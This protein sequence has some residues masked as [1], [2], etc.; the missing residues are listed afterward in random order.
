MSTAKVSE[1]PWLNPQEIFLTD[2][3][4]DEETT[5]AVEAVNAVRAAESESKDEACNESDVDQVELF[6]GNLRKDVEQ[7]L[8]ISKLQ[9][10]FSTIS[11]ELSIEKFRPLQRGSNKAKH[12]FVKMENM[13]D[14]EKIVDNFDGYSDSE[15]VFA[16]RT[17]K[18]CPKHYKPSRKRR[19]RKRKNSLA[20]KE[21]EC[22]EN[23]DFDK[24][25]LRRVEMIRRCMSAPCIV[26][27]QSMAMEE[28]KRDFLV[29]GQILKCEDRTTEYKRG[30]GKY[31]R[32][33]LMHDV[34]K[35]TCA[36]LN[37]EGGSLFIGVA[38]DGKV[39][40]IP[41]N[42]KE[43]DI[44]RVLIDNIIS[45]FQPPIFPKSYC[46]NFIPVLP[47]ADY[48]PVDTND[49]CFKVL[50]VKIFPP[51]A[52][53]NSYLYETDKGE[54]Y[55]RRDGSVQGPLKASQI[56]EWCKNDNKM[57]CE[58]HSV[59]EKLDE[60]LKCT[61][62]EHSSGAELLK[63]TSSNLEYHELQGQVFN[64]SS[65]EQFG[66][67][68]INGRHLDMASL[69]KLCEIEAHIRERQQNIEMEI[70]VLKD[71]YAARERVLQVELERAKCLLKKERK[72]RRPKSATCTLL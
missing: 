3:K 31:P 50:E 14:I 24:L 33:F 28:R 43:E 49:H 6:V 12:L 40:G 45:G 47:H 22:L 10:L 51:P 70:G 19:K 57:D 29:M 56:I 38:D 66:G 32:K 21:D 72:K 59:N 35:Y 11:V 53:G 65:K 8:V 23:I 61:S 55:I 62:E 17:L 1:D 4:D 18:V 48:E 13:E 68:S 52:K 41:S 37:S 64:L 20:R 34:R 30:G 5:T 39:F 69:K 58:N 9:S 54:A 60:S 67:I 15:I 27:Q 46:V 44:I 71:H 2:L 25:D 26:E 7:D 36:F 42:R 16:E 63:I